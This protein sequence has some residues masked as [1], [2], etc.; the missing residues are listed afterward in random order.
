LGFA[1]SRID[2]ACPNPKNSL[3]LLNVF[4]WSEFV[5][6]PTPAGLGI[7]IQPRSRDGLAFV[8]HIRKNSVRITREGGGGGGGGRVTDGWEW[9]RYVPRGGNGMLHVKTIQSK[10]TC[11]VSMG[12]WGTI[13]RR[14]ST[15]DSK[16]Q[17]HASDH[18]E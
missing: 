2:A 3:G 17:V 9:S 11:T 7:L 16:R 8:R 14:T 18:E 5:P 1:A 15:T 12:N 6:T 10:S 4:S 13:G